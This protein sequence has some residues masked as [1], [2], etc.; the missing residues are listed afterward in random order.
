MECKFVNGRL[1]F[2]LGKVVRSHCSLGW[3]EVAAN[4]A[5]RFN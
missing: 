2:M 3:A 4:D 5:K 1:R